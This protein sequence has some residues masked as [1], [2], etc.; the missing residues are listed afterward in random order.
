MKI[1]F[2]LGIFVVFGV[3]LCYYIYLLL[4]TK[5][6]HDGIPYFIGLSVYCIVC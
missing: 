6:Q 2:I 5:E 3:I 1:T 4:N